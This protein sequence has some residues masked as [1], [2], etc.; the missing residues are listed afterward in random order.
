MSIFIKVFFFFILFRLPIAQRPRSRR[1]RDS[2]RRADPNPPIHFKEYRRSE[3]KSRFFLRF[4]AKF[5]LYAQA[6]A[7]ERKEEHISVYFGFVCGIIG[8]EPTP[9][10]YEALK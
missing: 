8:V 2:E 4:A 1:A 9:Y 6:D 3:N 5:K 10:S 7:A